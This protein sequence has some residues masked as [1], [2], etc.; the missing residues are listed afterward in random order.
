MKKT[1][2]IIGM[3][4]LTCTLSLSTLF[5]QSP[6][7]MSYQSVIRNSSENVVPNTQV[8]MQ[9][10]IL[11][12]SLEGTVVYT[13]TQTPTTNANGL[14]SI[15]IGGGA[16]FSSINWASDIYFIKTET[17]PTGGTNY[18][19]TG[20]SQLLSVPYALH[21]KTAESITATIA[22][23]DPI[24]TN[25]QAANITEADITNLSNL[26]GVNTGDQDLSELATKTELDDAIAQIRTEI[27]PAVDGSETIVTAGTNVTITGIG[28]TDNPYIVNSTGASTPHYVGELF[29]GGV[30]FWVDETG[31]HGLICSMIDV[32]NEA[33]WSNVTAGLINRTSDWDGES[34]TADIIGQS[35]HTSSAALLC[36]NYTNDDYGTGTYSDWYLPSLG[37][38]ILIW[39]N[40]YS[41]QKSLTNSGSS[42]ATA[43]AKNIYWSS[44]QN[45][46]NTG[47]YYNMSEGG[48]N[49]SNKVTQ[50]RVRAVRAF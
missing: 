17:D 45:N 50:L 31:N 7:K 43:I 47:F 19:I 34:N 40:L 5:A 13:E 16:G 36:Q 1:F 10:S 4:L 14:V 9:I 11:Q 32:T 6:D 22:E 38:L 8:G 39:N 37:E 33:P 48:V 41:V 23:S 30:V 2:T 25:S 44:T 28:T 46:D 15:E 49:L 3:V 12:G 27:P 35:G 20:T 26:S 24:F 18:T 42:S 29:G 21:A